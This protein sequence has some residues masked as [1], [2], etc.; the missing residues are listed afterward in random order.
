M[1]LPPSSSCPQLNTM[2]IRE[3]DRTSTSD[4]GQDGT[5]VHE[6][7]EAAE[8]GIG[9]DREHGQ[10]PA[11]REVDS[12]EE[13]DQARAHAPPSSANAANAKKI[14]GMKRSNPTVKKGEKVLQILPSRISSISN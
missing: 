2:S 13:E 7:A 12:D 5:I 3:I 6:D 10:N 11:V 14:F 4:P 9:G 1:L 8:P